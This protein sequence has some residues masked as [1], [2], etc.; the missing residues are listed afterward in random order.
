MY[1][2]KNMPLFCIINENDKLKKCLLTLYN[3]GD[4]NGS[5]NKCTMD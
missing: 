2:L 4:E 5:D 1:T 3:L